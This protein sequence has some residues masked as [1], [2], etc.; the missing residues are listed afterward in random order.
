MLGIKLMNR[1]S[2]AVAALLIA[3]VAPVGRAAAREDSNH[4]DSYYS[5]ATRMKPMDVMHVIDTDKKGYV[6]RE[7]FMKFQE[8]FFDRMD[9]NHDGKVDAK[10]WMGKAAANK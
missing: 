10:E 7:E 5:L 4:A 1:R 6:T 9:K 8:E 3:V 2:L